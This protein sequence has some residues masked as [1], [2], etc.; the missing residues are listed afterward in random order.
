[1]KTFT[2]TGALCLVL[3]FILVSVGAV[4]WVHRVHEAERLYRGSSI[5]K[6]ENLGR[7]WREIL[8]RRFD[9]DMGSIR[10]LEGDL[11]LQGFFDAKAQNEELHR[12]ELQV[13]E[14][15]ALLEKTI[16]NSN[17]GVVPDWVEKHQTWREL[18]Q[19][20]SKSH[21]K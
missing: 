21:Q 8:S 10:M 6:L 14:N 15:F 7:Q 5:E 20:L 13:R 16:R 17:G 9:L 12:E 2:S 4:Y 18:D 11:Q 19:A 3:S 1:M